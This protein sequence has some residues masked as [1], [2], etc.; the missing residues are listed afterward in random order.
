MNRAKNVYDFEIG[1]YYHIVSDVGGYG[2]VKF[3]NYVYHGI[4]KL[5]PDRLSGKIISN[6][7]EVY[8][9]GNHL[10]YEIS[11]SRKDT[12]VY[13]TG[14]EFRLATKAE[15]MWL[16]YCIDNWSVLT[17]KMFKLILRSKI[18]DLLV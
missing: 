11:E 15:E 2:I 18:L 1:K 12:G 5:D 16:D 9:S 4:D 10:H 17:P 8:S 13:I 3:E 7:N 14:R 6:M